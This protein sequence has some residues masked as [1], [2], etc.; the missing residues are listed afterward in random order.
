MK[1]GPKAQ[2]AEPANRQRAD[3]GA[4]GFLFRAQRAAQ[5]TP[6]M[7]REPSSRCGPLRAALAVALSLMCGGVAAGQGNSPIQLRR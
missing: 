2:F 4:A 3:A 6:T 5:L 7:K 1:N